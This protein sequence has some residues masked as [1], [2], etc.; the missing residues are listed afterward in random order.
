M[1]WKHKFSFGVASIH[2]SPLIEAMNAH[3]H[4]EARHHYNVPG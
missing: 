4:A 2:G 3:Q 1:G